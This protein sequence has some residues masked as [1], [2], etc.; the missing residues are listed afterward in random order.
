MD[1]VAAELGQDPVEFRLRHLDNDPRLANTV[2]AAAKAYGWRRRSGPTGKG[3]GFACGID[4]GSKVAEVVEADVNRDTGEVKVKR[5]VAAHESGL[6][7]S[8]DGI[9]S[10]IEGAITMGLGPALRE[11]VRYRDGKILT[12]S[13]SSY[14]I[15]TTL[16]APRIET[17]LV[18]N[19]TH[20]PQ[21]AGE[22]AIFPIAGAVASAIF[23]ATGKRLRELPMSPERVLAAL[24]A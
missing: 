2:K 1:E 8:P 4:V 3:V 20:P 24:R 10:Q 11:V 19:P 7:I 16:D 23:D 9:T 6:V 22:P 17:T 13:F 12:D 15:P 21:G 5:V 14:P 18:P